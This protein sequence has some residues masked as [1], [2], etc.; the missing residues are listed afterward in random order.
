M[1]ERTELRYSVEVA[2]LESPGEW[3]SL[4]LRMTLEAAQLEIRIQRRD[5]R[6]RDLRIMDLQTGQVETE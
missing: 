6:S 5:L 2:A 4:A 1:V 3:T